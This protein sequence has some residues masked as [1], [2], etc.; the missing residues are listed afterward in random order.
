MLLKDSLDNYIKENGFNSEKQQLH[1][2]E[3][4]GVL[5]TSQSWR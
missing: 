3:K 2:D 5:R 1:V 4:V